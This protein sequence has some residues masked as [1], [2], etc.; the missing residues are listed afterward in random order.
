MLEKGNSRVLQSMEENVE[1]AARAREGATKNAL[2][3]VTNREEPFKIDAVKVLDGSELTF[4]LHPRLN[5]LPK[6]CCISYLDTPRRGAS[7]SSVNSRNDGGG[8]QH[9]NT[10]KYVGSLD[11]GSSTDLNLLCIGISD[12]ETGS[13]D[14]EEPVKEGEGSCS[15]R[16]INFTED[17][18]VELNRKQ[19]DSALHRE[20][21]RCK[22]RYFFKYSRR[23]SSLK[24]N[25]GSKPKGC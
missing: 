14:G 21:Q 20:E 10:C 5:S 12:M 24:P 25:L 16:L 11:S 7:T 3:L 6:S 4:E 22:D 8:H 19:A 1:V 13:K 15:G 2:S 18:S 23:N 9:N 17:N